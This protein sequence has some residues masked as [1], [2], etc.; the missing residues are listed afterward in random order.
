VCRGEGRTRTERS[1]GVEIPPGVS[2]QNYITLRGEGA[3]G[4]RGGP[5]GDLIVVI[6]IK[7]DERFTRDGDDLWLELP[8]AFSQVTLG[9]TLPVPTPWGDEELAV[10][11]G[12]Q[13][14]TVLK[15]RHKGLPKLGGN[16]TGDLNVRVQVWTPRRLSDEQRRLFGELAGHESEGPEHGGGFWSRLKEALGA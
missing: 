14:G 16:T 15:L 7:D 10:P 4:M 5:P 13:S 3:A 8:L 6:S 11:A 9:V 2:E 1:V 12:T